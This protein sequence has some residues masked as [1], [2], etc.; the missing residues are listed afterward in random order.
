LI[1]L[2]EVHG[3]H[4]GA[5][6]TEVMKP[7]LIEMIPLERLRF[8]QADNDS[9]CDT[10]IDSFLHDLRPDIQDPRSRRVRCLGHIINL[11]V[12]AFMKGCEV[13]D[14]EESGLS[15]IQQKRLLEEWRNKGFY[16]KLH[17]LVVFIRASPQRRGTFKALGIVT[18]DVEGFLNE[19]ETGKD[20]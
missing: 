19:V 6:V 8:F 15:K 14:A 2:K 9:K 20:E 5:N 11:V 7:V 10:A 12:Q 3:S 1:G 4:A 17:N 13:M 16:G 18:D